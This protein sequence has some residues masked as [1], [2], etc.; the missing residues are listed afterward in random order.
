[1]D[2]EQIGNPPSR[3]PLRLW[4][5]VVAVGRVYTFGATGIVNALDA[6]TGAVVWSRNA[7]SDTG[8]TRPEWAYPSATRHLLDVVERQHE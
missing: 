8:A 7:Q 3:K 2:I 1:M 4:P 6:T 5:G